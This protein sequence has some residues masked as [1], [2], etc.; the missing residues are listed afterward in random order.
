MPPG[1]EVGL[2]PGDIVLHEDIVLDGDP[3]PHGK[4]H[5]SPTIVAIRSLVLATAELL[6]HL[7]SCYANIVMYRRS[8]ESD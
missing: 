2:G 6:S 1:M 4:G 3:A 7:A 8:S 5:C